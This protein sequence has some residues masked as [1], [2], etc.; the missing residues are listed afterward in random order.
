MENLIFLIGKP[1][2]TW[3]HGNLE[4][5][6]NA[7]PSNPLPFGTRSSRSRLDI[8]YQ[9]PIYANRKSRKVDS[10]IRSADH[11]NTGKGFSTSSSLA[12]IM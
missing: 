1:W 5:W 7:S 8:R 6:K 10:M 9:T 12:D 11:K 3:E 2:E 4:T